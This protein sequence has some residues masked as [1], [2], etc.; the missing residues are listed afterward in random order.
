VEVYVDGEKLYESGSHNGD[1]NH[2]VKFEVKNLQ[3][4][5]LAV[6]LKIAVMGFEHTFQVHQIHIPYLSSPY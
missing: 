6:K 4:Q 2:E 1:V 5:V 3:S